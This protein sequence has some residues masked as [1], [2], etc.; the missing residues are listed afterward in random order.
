MKV[1]LIDYTH[2]PIMRMADAA[3]N[4]YD[5][6]P[7][8]AVVH[9]CIKSGHESIA[10]FASFHFRLSEVSRAFSHQLVR[11]RMASFAQRSQRYVN[12][13]GF[14]FVTPPGIQADLEM[15]NKYLDFMVKCRALYNEFI[16]NGIPGD[17]ARMILPNACHTTINVYMNFRELMHFC[18]ERMCARASWEIRETANLMAEQVKIVEPEL[19]QY[20]VPKCKRFGYCPE[21]KGC[22]L[23]KVR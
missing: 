6:A 13:D 11:H 17:D 15:L 5:S 4:C 20:L 12:E 19:A 1:S 23:C 18:N 22:G 14:N 16:A 9:A 7:N 3:S 2:N 8:P 21:K 10:E